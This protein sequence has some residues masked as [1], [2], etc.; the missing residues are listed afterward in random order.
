MSNSV[1]AFAM[2]KS[3]SAASLAFTWCQL[4]FVYVLDEDAEPGLE[5]EFDDGESARFPNAAL[6]DDISA[7]IFERTGRVCKVTATMRA[8]Q[9][10]DD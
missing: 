6:P 8:D 3:R 4:P 5:V 2:A 1:R 10:F 7:H 9:L